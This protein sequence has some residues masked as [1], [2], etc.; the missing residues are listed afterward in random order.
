MLKRTLIVSAVCLI[1]LMFIPLSSL[2][3]IDDQS[4]QIQMQSGV[5]DLAEWD[6]G[7]N[8]I[9][10]LDGEWEFYWNQLLT[11]EHF[12]FK[13]A[14]LPAPASFIQVPSIWNSKEMNGQ[15]LPTYGYATYRAKLIN[16]PEN[17]IYALKKSNIRFSSAIYVNGEKLL[18][19]GR[20]DADRTNY[21]PGNFPQLSSFSSSKDEVEIIIQVA[22]Y[23]YLNAGIPKPIYFGEQTA[24][25]EYQQR[26]VSFE[27]SIFAILVVLALVYLICFIM[28]YIYR[29]K[30]YSLLL[31]ASICILFAVYHGLMGERVLSMLLP[32][33]SF[34]VIYKVKDISSIV[35][36]ILLSIFFYMLDRSILSLKFTRAIVFLLSSYTLMIALLPIRVYASIF[37]YIITVYELLLIWLLFRVAM[38]Y[39]RSAA[40]DRVR[41]FIH[42]M[43]ILC[44]NLYSLD[45]IL[46]AFT[47]RNQFFSGQLYIIVFN[48]LLVFFIA[49][50]FIED[51]RMIESMKNQLLQMD[52]IKDDFLSN[53]SHELKT[54]LNAIVNITDT[55]LQGAE[56]EITE[57]QA[58]NL[59]IVKDSGRRLTYLVNDLLDYSK[60]KH[61][62]ITLYT[63]RIDLKAAVDAVIKVHLFLL[64]NKMISLENDIPDH[65]QPIKADGN[66]LQQILHNLI[67]N[68]I[69]Y[70]ESG[71][72]Q[73]YGSAI[74]GMAHITV[75]DTGI[76]IPPEQ[77]AR[78]FI[79]FEQLHHQ[80][81]QNSGTG[82]GLSI[83]KNLVELHG[84]ALKVESKLEEGSSF[85]FT[86][87][88]SDGTPS[89]AERHQQL[90][91]GT[92]PKRDTVYP[93]Y[94]KGRLNEPILVV[95]DDYANL[96]SM[97]NLLKLEGYTFVVVNRGDL[98]LEVL[99][100]QSSFYLVILD[101]MMPDMS[102]YEV[103]KKIR[104]RFTL[105][106]L[107]VLMLTANNKASELKAA[108]GSGANDFVGKPY[109]AEELMARVRSLTRLKA[110]IQ[111][112]RASEIAFLR[113][114]INPHFLYNALNAIAELC[115]I[116]PSMAE[117]LTLQLSIYLRSS[118]DFKQLDSLTS[119]KNELE[120]VKAYISIEKARFGDRLT[121]VYDIEPM[122]HMAIPPLILQPLVENAV[123][124]GLMSKA[125]GGCVKLIVK[126]VGQSTIS[127]VVEDN[128]CGMSEQ[129]LAE[130]L[131]P[132]TEHKGV[133]LWNISQRLKLL[134]DEEIVIQSAE[135][136]GTRVSFKVPAGTVI[137]KGG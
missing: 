48:I 41:A 85:T 61:G 14:D 94:V 106:E 82:L 11:P 25:S 72:V 5:M 127:F 20:P 65:F 54:P 123:R 66:R 118:F 67:G 28:A 80:M 81:E 114:Q 73:I 128:G 64:E 76:G 59:A 122:L 96:Q 92:E 63:D 13:G 124:H 120:L 121:L 49:H 119:L 2:M 17:M 37:P 88:L 126:S 103:L 30:D 31:F 95:D 98:A 104:E 84:G 77:Q 131:E 111:S 53:T 29:R 68:A 109:E 115:I 93:K 83:V 74:D 10:K 6:V 71:S 70:T 99:A 90:R 12:S 7:A 125:Q 52:K 55:L 78:L 97:T 50:R 33:F 19:D 132:S 56:G 79:P 107:P 36:F 16:V 43:G 21:E 117:E 116:D 18:E 135:G 44:I 134:Y 58:R 9:I 112:A 89:K 75:K 101:I 8:P 27:A 51:Y 136:A 130:V 133:G 86:I 15:P 62:D 108:V 110:S 26:I 60:M 57:Q 91:I 39:I 3:D 35:C 100:G 105:F 4:E 32:R 23:D 102:G 24:M 38:L 69:K 137:K 22:N 129:R 40:I 46:F 87:P 113:S 47:V 42:F 34:E 1:L 45:I